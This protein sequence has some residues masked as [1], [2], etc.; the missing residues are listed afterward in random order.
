MQILIPVGI[1]E[2]YDKISILE[3]KNERITDAGKLAYVR[4]ELAELKAVAEAHPVDMALYQDLKKVNEALWKIE[5]DIREKE[6]AGAFDAEFI[7][8]ARSVYKNNDERAALKK[9]M[10]LAAGSAIVEVKSYF[11]KK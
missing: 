7:A 11:E 2:L 1:G 9:K 10:N 8:L 5:D 6:A 4:A 3:I